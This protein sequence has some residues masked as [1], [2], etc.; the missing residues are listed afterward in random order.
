MLMTKMMF[1]LS[2]KCKN[3]SSASEVDPMQ[4]R[5]LDCWTLKV[6]TAHSLGTL[7]TL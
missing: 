3:R 6:Q 5:L 1:Y 4:E 2:R 7:P